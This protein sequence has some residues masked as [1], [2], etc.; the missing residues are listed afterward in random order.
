LPT[1]ET[2]ETNRA[3][4]VSCIP[5]ALAQQRI[6]SGEKAMK[7]LSALSF[8]GITLLAIVAT[9]GSR[10]RAEDTAGSDA[11][12]KRLFG[13][14]V[15]DGKKS[16]ACF[17]RTY[18]AAHLK[19]HPLQKVTVMKLLITGETMPD[20][21]LTY[22]F[23]LG[24]NFRNRPGNFDSS[25]DCHHPEATE[26]TTDKI[27]LSCGVDCDGGS[28][29]V[30][31]TNSDKS[32]LISLDRIRIWRGNN[33]E[34]DIELSAGQD[35]KVFRLDRTSVEACRGLITDRKELAAL[36]HR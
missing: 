1:A 27:D 18:D 4:A 5:A 10:A 14:P 2:R 28:I 12:T 6:G 9:S 21:G 31:L 7:Y 35:D 34:A 20:Y 23:R 11:F 8:A 17:V 36:R 30:Q 32:T 13:G 22:S 24:V 16:Y 29:S 25:G 19:Q 15:A 3:P 33:P 26:V